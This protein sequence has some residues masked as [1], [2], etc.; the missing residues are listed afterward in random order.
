MKRTIFFGPPGT[1]KTHT[2]LQ[3]MEETIKGGIA[4]ESIAFLTFTRR[5]RLEA[6]TRVEQTLGIK[7]KDLPYFRTIHSLAYRAL[8]LQEGDVLG[9][10]ALREFGEGMGLEF[11]DVAASEQAAEGLTSGNKGDHLLGIDNLARLR[12]KPAQ[13]IW[14]EVSSPY[15]WQTVEHFMGSYAA[16]K[17]DRALLD[18]TDVLQEFVRQQLRVPVEVSIVD[19]AQDLAPLQWL[20]ALQAVEQGGQQYV[21]GDD[22][23]A[24]YRWAGAEVEV[25]QDLPGEKQ[26]LQHSYR[27]PRAVH[28][29]SNKIL[30]RIRRRVSKA[31]LPR[32]ALGVVKMHA[33]AES[34]EVG[35]NEK[36]LWLVRN[37][38]LMVALKDRLENE[39]LVYGGHEWCSINEQEREAIYAWEKLRAGKLV[40]TVQARDLYKA[41]RTKTQVKHGHKLIP[42][43]LDE[44]NLSYE[45][46]RGKHG[47][48]IERTAP[49]Y[50]VLESVPLTRRGYYRRL[51][52]K[53]NTLRLPVQVTLDTIHG[54]K[55]AQCDNVALFLEQARRTNLE[56]NT[57]P[58]DEHR[59]WYV[60]A[61]RAKEALHLVRAASPYSYAFP[62]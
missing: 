18:F 34:L 12:G 58:D 31:F 13:E 19:E 6:V 46:L 55:G 3:K 47:L 39:G 32:D 33:G 24:I 52:R 30:T 29:V 10:A 15:D 27:L 7:T 16:F 26:V 23:Q 59:V 42:G 56:A 54:A 1:G 57:A 11:G 17:K 38:F 41:L 4:P 50:E 21:A 49:W 22:D 61:T 51:L 9:K 14:K 40:T 5:A 28:A 8:K 44:A 36:W 35:K 43:E 45:E 48:L 62:K 20:A 37:R 25:F 2:L 53:H 60:G